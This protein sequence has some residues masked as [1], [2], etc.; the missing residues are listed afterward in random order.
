MGLD[1]SIEFTYYDKGSNVEKNSIEIAYWR[2][3]YAMRDTLHEL[4]NGYMY[5]IFADFYIGCKPESSVLTAVEEKLTSLIS[6]YEN[7]KSVPPIEFY[8]STFKVEDTVDITKAQLLRIQAANRLL[9]IR[10]RLEKG[11]KLT[12]ELQKLIDTNVD[13]VCSGWQARYSDML[14]DVI[15][16]P[17]LYDIMVSFYNSY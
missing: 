8:D 12:D 14:V 4:A 15:T 1:Y 3:C 6:Q 7:E 13:I 10:E 2:K 11:E 9:D 16:H 5:A 17:D